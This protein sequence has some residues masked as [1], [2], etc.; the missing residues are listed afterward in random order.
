MVD[1]YGAFFLKGGE[2]LK[3]LSMQ[4]AMYESNFGRHFPK[5]AGASILD[6]GSGP[7]LF[8]QW[9]SKEKGF[10]DVQGIDVDA[11]LIE[12]AKARGMRATLVAPGAETYDWLNANGPFDRVFMI[13]VL[14]HVPADA[15]APLLKAIAARLKPSGKIVLRVP[16]AAGA[17]AAV[18]RYDDPTHLTLFGVKS[19]TYEIGQGGLDVEMIHDDDVYFF[20]SP[21]EAVKSALR[22]FFRCIHRVQAVVDFGRYGARMPLSANIVAVGRPKAHS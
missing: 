22:A 11:T 2:N 10:F 17:F 7:G 6:I 16:N 3:S 20:S 21:L 18:L 4:W 1:N 19:L 14:E 13:D 9:A 5:E 12:A 8:L 15:R